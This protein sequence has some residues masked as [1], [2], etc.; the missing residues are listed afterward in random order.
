M[1]RPTLNSNGSSAYD[2]IE[3]RAIARR[4]L[5]QAI[6][7]LRSVM[8]NGRDYP[9]DNDLCVADRAEMYRRIGLLAEMQDDLLYE[10]VAI[11]NQ[12]G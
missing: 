5:Q 12:L 6:D 4:H 8:P 7:A 1:I 3:N 11:K 10:A 9:I 2:L